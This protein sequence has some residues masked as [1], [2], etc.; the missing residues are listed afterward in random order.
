MQLPPL[1]HGRILN[2]YKRFLADV[3]LD[4][5]RVITAHCP[6]TGAMSGCWRP[7]APAEVSAAAGRTRRLAWTLERVDMGRGWVGVHTGRA[8][9]VVAEGIRNGR[10]AGLTGY[11]DLRRE[12]RV[13]TARN[14]ASRLDMVLSGAAGGPEAVLEVKNATLLDGDCVRFPDAVTVRGLKH[15]EVLMDAVRAGYRAVLLFAVN[16][17]EG[18]CLAPAFA[19]DPVYARTLAAAADAGVEV[20]AQRVRH[21][22]TGMEVGERLPV[23]LIW[24]GDGANAR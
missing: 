18:S 8:N 20:L 22:A 5:G 3:E 13:T 14:G 4:D 23:K 16:R 7:G 11:T 10:I 6:N 9:E 19:I 2:R 15:I 12:V 17:P 1:R 21:T 24:P